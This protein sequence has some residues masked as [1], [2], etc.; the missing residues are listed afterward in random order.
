MWLYLSRKINWILEMN[1]NNFNML[2]TITKLGVE[3]RADIGIF[4]LKLTYMRRRFPIY[5]IFLTSW[6]QEI[7]IISWYQ[8]I[9]SLLGG[10]GNDRRKYYVVDVMIEE[11]IYTF[12]IITTNTYCNIYM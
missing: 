3:N 10:R 4:K 9:T 2:F 8:E 5:S 7:E 11:N 6:Y 1:V 12:E